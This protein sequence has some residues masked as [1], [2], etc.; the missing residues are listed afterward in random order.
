L[1]NSSFNSLDAERPTPLGLQVEKHMKP[2]PNSALH[3]LALLLAASSAI[4][5]SP[6]QK[7]RIAFDAQVAGKPFACGTT[8]DN[9]GQSHARIKARDLRFFVSQVELLTADGRAIPLALNQ[10]G[11]WQY[12][13]LALLDFEDG[14]A[15]CL[16]GNAGINKQVV[17]TVP[18]G[19]YTGLR[20]SLGVPF[21]LDHIDAASAPSPLN[22]TAMFWSWQ[23]G[24]KFLRA[25]VVTVASA[26]A[27][28]AAMP[29]SMQMNMPHIQHPNG[30][31]VHVGSTGCAVADVAAVPAKECMHPNRPT[32]TFH[33]FAIDHD[34]VVFDLAQLLAG[35]DLDSSAP[36]A[37]PG[38]MSFPGSAACTAPMRA[39]GL[40]FDGAPAVEQTV[41]IR[42]IQR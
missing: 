40:A 42:E 25:E 20:F 1:F 30:F 13:N 22:T 35:V 5:Q 11:I 19:S 34:T 39:L 16:N 23:D 26:L 7:I 14:A 3:A 36:G 33:I 21:E 32:I 18:A 17:G 12:K 10:D 15:S 41:F 8:Y 27:P 2:L 24:F 38:C 28:P 31:P 6:T 9:I 4:A 29:A 37:S